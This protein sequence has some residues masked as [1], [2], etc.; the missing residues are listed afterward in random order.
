MSEATIAL[1]AMTLGIFIVLLGFFIW[2]IM[3]GQFRNVEDAKYQVFRRQK[4]STKH[5]DE[6]PKKEVKSNGKS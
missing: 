1:T 6:G 4:Q 3:S 5:G 2:G